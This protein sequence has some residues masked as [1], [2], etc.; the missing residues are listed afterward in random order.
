MESINAIYALTTSRNPSTEVGDFSIK[1][2]NVVI[3][4]PR[5]KGTEYII[6]SFDK[7]EIKPNFKTISVT[8]NDDH[9]AFGCAYWQHY[10]NTSDISSQK[11]N[12]LNIEKKFFIEK[13][14]SKGKILEEVNSK[15]PIK[16]GD[17]VIV[18]ITIKCNDKMDFVMIE[19]QFASGFEPTIKLSGYRF[20]ERSGYY[21]S[22]TDSSILYFFDYLS[23]G[24]YV[25]E[26]QLNAERA[27][28]YTN[29]IGQI[30]CLYAPEFI[31]HTAGSKLEIT[32]KH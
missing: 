32:N 23:K 31:N 24:T 15:N 28:L 17:K 19:D 9:F 1:V 4:K 3:D 14:T 10:D 20:S 7:E 22:Y 8:K 29:G 5:V 11:G 18:R 25:F 6:Q 30:Q 2:G 27:G 26:Y 13:P 21:L 16:I 12:K